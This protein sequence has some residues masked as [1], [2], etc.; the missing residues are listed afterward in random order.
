MTARPRILVADSIAD[1]GV[2]RLGEAGEVD[3]RTG[4]SPDEL[5]AAA[6]PYS[7]I[8]V[9]S[10]SRITRDVIAA[11]PQLVVV[12]RAGVGVDNI[13]LEAATERGVIVVN[14]PQGNTIAAA[15]HTVALMLALARHVSAADASMRGGHWA[16]S[17][18]LGVEIRGKTLGVIGLGNV[19]AEVARRA[20]G[21]EM[22]LLGHDPFVAVERAAA[23]GVEVCDLDRIYR[24][25]DFI[26]VHVPM[27]A[28]NRGMIGPAEI[29]VMKPTV[30]LIN[31]SRG[32]II[33]EQA[34]ADALAGGKVAGAAVDV[35]TD[36][37]PAPD[38]PLLSAPNIILTPHL[39]ASTA[40]AQER[41]A[42]DVADQIV[43]VLNGRLARYAVNAP[44]L[45]PETLRIVGPFIP[46]A[47]AIGAIG[48]Q[49]ITGNLEAIEIDYYGD[50]AEHDVA[51]LRA[52]VIKG[53]MR[54]ISEENVNLVNAGHVAQ[55][56]GWHI[57]ERLRDSHN[58]FHNLIH[59][60]LT[61]SE[62]EVTVAGSV[63]HG[64]QPNIVV[65]N[66]LDVDLVPEAGSYL[67]ICDN[68]DRPGM[69]G[70]LGTLLGSYDINISAMQVGRTERR[71][72]ALM[73][74][75]LDEG[76]DEAQQAEIAA[77]DGIYNVRI[78]R[79]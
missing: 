20:T 22:H 14:A 57:D 63:R 56:R 46:V 41:A 62:S 64:G 34:L 74:L 28:A 73:I 36:E 60:K 78:V 71:G 48:T 18:F 17:K 11:A 12:G 13:D 66:G 79:L 52:S 35:F 23:L 40:E 77:I 6:A 2:A 50:I 49:L 26:T 32:G 19:G 58:V 30:R 47:E 67:L 68:D 3:V 25:A 53:L 16:R 9:R 54:P 21:L 38:N 37:P 29:A 69:I 15:E 33:D 1:E 75:A 55:G 76:P 44:L 70:R 72:R 5:R 51:P 61:T 8:V 4:L 65:L 43:D 10:A 39:G 27:T 24:E 31:V 7:A 42:L 59:L 45:P